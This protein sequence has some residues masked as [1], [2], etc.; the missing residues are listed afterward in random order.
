MNTPFSDFSCVIDNIRILSLPDKPGW[1]DV[2]ACFSVT[3]ACPSLCSI[4]LQ[5]SHR[6]CGNVGAQDG[7]TT[8]KLL[9]T[10]VC[11][12]CL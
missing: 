7:L 10:S 8:L 1:S 12:P 11:V 2:S 5:N 3:A 6:P 4:L 9:S